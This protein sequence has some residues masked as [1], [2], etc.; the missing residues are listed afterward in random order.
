MPEGGA[1]PDSEAV[2][3]HAQGLTT[4]GEE[5]EEEAGRE[6]AF[7]GICCVATTGFP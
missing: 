4:K 1:P 6:K 2:A 3:I 5:E 7:C